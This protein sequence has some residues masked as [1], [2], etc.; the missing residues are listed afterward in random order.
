MSKEELLYQI[1]TLEQENKQLKEKIDEAI[2]FINQ[3]ITA[4]TAPRVSKNDLLE[5]LLGDSDE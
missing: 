1:V 2:Y 5:I 3:N 4:Y